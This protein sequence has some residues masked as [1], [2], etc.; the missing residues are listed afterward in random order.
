MGQQHRLA[1]ADLHG[2][3]RVQREKRWTTIMDLVLISTALLWV[4]SLSL[5]DL[6]PVHA[7]WVL[8]V[9]MVAMVVHRV[10]V[11][12]ERRRR[13]RSGLAAQREMARAAVR[14]APADAH[15]A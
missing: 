13:E 8:P 11:G 12:V 14:R 3:A 9:V 6:L 1:A 4:A 2:L 7:R 10:L 5:D 15:A